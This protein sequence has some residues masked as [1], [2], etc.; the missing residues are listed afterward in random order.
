MS[1]ISDKEYLFIHSGILEN[2]QVER[3]LKEV[4]LIL[5]E[6]FEPDIINTEIEVNVVKNKEGK[7]FGHAYC[8]ISD[9]RVSNVLIGN[10]LDG[11]E[12]VKEVLDE[13]WESPEEDYDDAMENAGGDWAEMTLVEFSYVRPTKK[14]LLEPL[15]TLPA[16]QYTEEQKIEVENESSYGFLEIFPIKISEKIGKLNSIFSDNIPGWIT[17]KM[18]LDRFK[19]YN[20]DKTVYTEKKTKKKFSYPLVKIR[21]KK[22][23]RGTRNFCTISFSPIY[24]NTASFLINLVKRVEFSDGNKKELL[25]FSQT[26][27]RNN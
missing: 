2:F 18:L 17:E 9:V 23:A 14:I 24:R 16:I 5:S 25:F 21:K 22:D 10:N 19:K 6:N 7:K 8:W 12:R 3:C 11:T 27:S 13:E 4:I 15:V 26:K 20:K 1:K